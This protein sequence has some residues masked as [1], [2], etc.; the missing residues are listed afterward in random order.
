MKA[1]LFI[2]VDAGGT[3]TH[4]RIRDH[5][6]D[7]LSES[8][9]GS[10]NV[11]TD[12]DGAI[13]RI[14]LAIDDAIAHAKLND[15]KRQSLTLGVGLAGLVSGSDPVRIVKSFSDFG[16]VHV[17]SDAETACLGAH[18]GADGGIVIA[19]TGSAGFARVKKKTLAIGGR[20]FL[21]S[22]E[23]SAARIGADALRGA[24]FA[25]DGMTEKTAFHDKI[26][27]RFDDDPSNVTAW[28]KAAT[29]SDYGALAP[30]IFGFAEKGDASAID[31]IKHHADA[32]IAHALR[33]QD[34]G[35]K[36]ICLVGGLAPRIAPW[37]A[38][39]VE[40]LFEASLH[41]AADGAILLAGGVVT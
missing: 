39:E 5:K 16:K 3:K 12:H 41:D 37:I 30:I 15:T 20:G 27:R 25:A 40:G 26:L 32:L 21:V 14:R 1:T 34:F 33:L 28:A 11:H 10:G 7:L 29:P 2:G 36:R 38:L 22:D 24:V 17:A 23:G 18:K 4:V 8:M 6:G 35:A 13:G 31:I 19:G 9:G